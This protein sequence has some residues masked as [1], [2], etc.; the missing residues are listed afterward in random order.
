M[1]IL[2]LI[3][4]IFVS[5]I[6]SIMLYKWI[7]KKEKDDKCKTIYKNAFVGGIIAIFKIVLVSGVLFIIGKIS[8]LEKISPLLYQFYYTFFALAFAEELVKFLT[9]KKVLKKNQYEYS[10]FNLT[11]IMVMV[12]L[13]FGFIE[14]VVFSIGSGIIEM[15]LK[16]ISLG[17]AG[18]GF[19]MGWLYGKMLKTGKK[20]YGV[21]GFIIPW[22]LHGLYDFG[23]SKEL[24]DVN[25]NFAIISVSLEALC[26]VVTFLIIRF[27][28]K[29]KDSTLYIEPLDKMSNNIKD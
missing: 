15:L 27:V 5:L 6:P 18:Y 13:G 25:D 20:I 22:M 8:G 26:L 11:I 14:N 21:L 1:D 2:V 29:R 3:V 17:H 10:W 16:G 9:F 12:G 4:A 23:L 7:Q 19:I 24:I 28:R